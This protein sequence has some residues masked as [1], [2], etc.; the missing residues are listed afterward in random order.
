[1][2]AKVIAN[3]FVV[4]LSTV[5]ISSKKTEAVARRYSIK[6]IPAGGGGRNVE[7]NQK[8]FPAQ[9]FYCEFCETFQNSFFIEHFQ[10]LKKGWPI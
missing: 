9:V 2:F 8:R 6:K 7:L 10:A 4:L 5:Y 1:M 3:I